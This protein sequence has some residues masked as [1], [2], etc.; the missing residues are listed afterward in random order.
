MKTEPSERLAFFVPTLE[1]GGAEKMMLILAGAFAERGYE[2]DLIVTRAVGEHAK[3]VPALV[4]LVDLSVRNAPAALIPLA[5]YLRAHRPLALLSTLSHANVVAIWAAKLARAGTPV[6]VREANSPL[7]RKVSRGW[8]NRVMTTL[9]RFSYP[10]AAR[11]ISISHDLAAEIVQELGLPPAHVVT[12]YSPVVTPALLT[13]SDAPPDHP[14]FAPSNRAPVIV[15]AGRLTPQKDFATL[16][17]S[18]ALLRGRLDARLLILGEGSQ[19]GELERLGRELKIDSDLSMPGFAQNPIPF[20]SHASVFALSS[21]WEGFGNVLVEAM[22]CGTPVVSTDCPSGPREI[23]GG[24]EYG[25]L[26]AVGDSER[27]AEA[28]E[29]A[30]TTPK[31]SDSLRA[32]AAEFSLETSVRQYEQ[33]LRGA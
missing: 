3:S 14:W 30:I 2:V 7:G 11:V 29:R 8:R 20:F 10:R 1:G 12:I 5:R 21:A 18:F 32:R 28:L 4:R 6:F 24:G 9:Q 16:L 17:R 19:R 26:V 15:A 31:N 23:L 22:A 13:G 25:E 33:V 27:L